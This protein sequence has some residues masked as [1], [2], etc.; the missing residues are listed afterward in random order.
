MLKKLDEMFLKHPRE[1]NVSYIKHLC[2]SM[3]LSVYFLTASIQAFIHALVPCYFETS[4]S[5]FIKILEDYMK[6]TYKEE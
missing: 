6:N 4:S 1:K 5:D 2:V 3:S